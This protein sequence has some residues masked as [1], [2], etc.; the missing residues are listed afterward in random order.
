MVCCRARRERDLQNIW[1]DLLAR[2]ALEQAVLE[3]C[4]QAFAVPVDKGG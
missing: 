1:D 2:H 3:S 4:A